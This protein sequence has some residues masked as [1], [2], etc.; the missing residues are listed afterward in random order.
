MYVQDSPL[1]IRQFTVYKMF[2]FTFFRLFD[3]T[4]QTTGCSPCLLMWLYWCCWWR[5]VLDS[6]MDILILKLK[7]KDYNLT[8]TE[9]YGKLYISFF[10]IKKLNTYFLIYWQ[11]DLLKDQP[12]YFSTSFH[13]LSFQGLLF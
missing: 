1:A 7:S 4:L 8:S 11:R 10:L 12:I 6:I 13:G 3:S 2:L 9:I 5:T